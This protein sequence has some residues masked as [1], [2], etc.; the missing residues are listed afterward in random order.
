MNKKI[1]PT[2][3][4]FLN[5]ILDLTSAFLNRGKKE[6]RKRNLF[7][8]VLSGLAFGLSLV[9]LCLQT[10]IEKHGQ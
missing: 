8:C 10:E 6:R 2:M 3:M 4:Y 5:L 9:D 7:C 1:I